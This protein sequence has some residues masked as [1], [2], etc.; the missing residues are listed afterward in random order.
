MI[1]AF[2]N[3]FLSFYFVLIGWQNNIRLL[4]AL[5]NIGKVHE[6]MKSR[7]VHACYIIVTSMYS[8]YIRDFFK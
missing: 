8:M 3:V 5:F 7:K 6:M 4:V 1:F 2:L